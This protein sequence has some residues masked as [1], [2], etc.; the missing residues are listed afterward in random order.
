MVDNEKEQLGPWYFE[1]MREF[2]EFRILI[3]IIWKPKVSSFF[4][5]SYTDE[6]RLFFLINILSFIYLFFFRIGSSSVR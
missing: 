4:N 3:N 2:C 5:I 1:R 6:I